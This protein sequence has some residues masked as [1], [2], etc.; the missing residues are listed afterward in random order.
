MVK[1]RAPHTKPGLVR[2]LH[3][4]HLMTQQE[5]FRLVRDRHVRWMG[6]AENAGI[7][8]KHQEIVALLEEVA[9]EYADLIVMLKEQ[10]G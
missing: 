4:D 1:L 8:A 7:R 2:N 5:H 6:E 10:E 9:A 3:I